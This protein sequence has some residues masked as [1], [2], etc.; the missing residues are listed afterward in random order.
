M[1]GST[2]LLKKIRLADLIGY[3][4]CQ[5]PTHLQIILLNST[6]F[7][8]VPPLRLCCISTSGHEITKYLFV[9]AKWACPVSSHC[10]LVRQREPA[11]WFTKTNPTWSVSSRQETICNGNKHKRQC[12]LFYRDNSFIRKFQWNFLKWGQQLQ[13]HYIYTCSYY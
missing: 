10:G 11:P 12:Q 3:D 6:H 2:V 5:L 7:T 4:C 8:S 9:T 13:G 1:T